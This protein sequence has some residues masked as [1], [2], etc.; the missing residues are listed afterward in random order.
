[1]ADDT[2][3]S[4]LTERRVLEMALP[5]SWH[6]ASAFH[7]LPRPTPL[8]CLLQTQREV[9]SESS[10]TR[11]ASPAGGSDP[12]SSEPGWAPVPWAGPWMKQALCATSLAVALSP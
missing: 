9:T 2:E 12:G 11:R 1:M 7:I 6:T 5:V 8:L 3:P 10:V 4:A